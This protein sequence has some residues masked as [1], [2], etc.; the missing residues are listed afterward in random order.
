MFNR[1]SSL[2]NADGTGLDNYGFTGTR[3][4]QNG[5][6]P[7]E[8]P[9]EALALVNK[10]I[11]GDPN[12]K[13]KAYNKNGKLKEEPSILYELNHIGKGIK[14]D[15]KQWA[16]LEKD[17][18]MVAKILVDYKFNTGR[19]VKDLITIAAGG[20]WDGTRAAGPNVSDATVLKAID[21][22]DARNRYN[23]YKKSNK[24]KD[25]D[26]TL[27]F[28]T[29]ELDVTKMLDAREDLYTKG[30]KFN[31]SAWDNSQKNRI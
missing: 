18:P 14:L 29:N 7:P 26:Y 5:M 16:E 4:T 15:K 17:N 25:M 1:E 22:P 19:S 28:L 3:F 2:G 21:N 11:I 31:Q 30:S 6:T 27:W 13:T 10:E 8:T 9:E 24:G 23:T 12:T 20:D